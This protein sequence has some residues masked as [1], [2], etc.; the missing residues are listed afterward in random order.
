MILSN[1]ARLQESAG[2]GKMI[3][4]LPRE[5]GTEE[6]FET[7]FEIRGK[8]AFFYVRNGEPEKTVRVALPDNAMGL[9]WAG[10]LFYMYIAGHARL[11]QRIYTPENHGK[12]LTVCDACGS[13][14]EPGSMQGAG[15]LPSSHP[16][17]IDGKVIEVFPDQ[18][19]YVAAQAAAVIFPHRFPSNFAETFAETHTYAGRDDYQRAHPELLEEAVNCQP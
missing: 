17:Y 9:H 4:R 16:E 7:G 11:L 18:Q 6:A 2:L 8:D 14:T 1:T 10:Q 3:T 15:V 5:D 13:C 12:T 19:A